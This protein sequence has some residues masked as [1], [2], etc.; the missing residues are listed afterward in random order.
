MASMS[1]RL[2]F[3]A[4]SECRFFVFTDGS[5]RRGGCRPGHPSTRRVGVACVWV[6]ER[7]GPGYEHGDK[8]DPGDGGSGLQELSIKAS[9]VAE[10]LLLRKGR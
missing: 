5:G 9:C 6:H 1:N 4:G 7:E 3:Q 2:N 8:Y 10:R